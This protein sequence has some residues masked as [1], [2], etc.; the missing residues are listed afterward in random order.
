LRWS[1]GIE[2]QDFMIEWYR[3]RCLYICRNKVA[4]DFR[5]TSDLENNFKDVVLKVDLKV[6]IIQYQMQKKSFHGY[7]IGWYNRS[8]FR[9]AATP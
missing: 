1:D 4:S 3:T 9:K 5:V 6:T 7:F 2:D 8:L